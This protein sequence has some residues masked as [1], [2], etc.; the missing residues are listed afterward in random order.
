MRFGLPAGFK[1]VPDRLVVGPH[2]GS[3]IESGYTEI[4]GVRFYPDRL[5]IGQYGQPELRRGRVDVPV[6]STPGRLHLRSL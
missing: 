5:V 4:S 3:V 1:S 2:G 6:G